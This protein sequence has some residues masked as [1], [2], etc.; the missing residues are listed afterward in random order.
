MKSTTKHISVTEQTQNDN[1]HLNWH[2]VMSGE[3][4]SV[5]YWWW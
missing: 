2:R 5:T 4:H 1:F 3:Y